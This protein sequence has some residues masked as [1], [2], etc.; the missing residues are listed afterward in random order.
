MQ[1]GFHRRSRSRRERVILRQYWRG[2]AALPVWTGGH[3]SDAES[4]WFMCLSMSSLLRITVQGKQQGYGGQGGELVHHWEGAGRSKDLQPCWR[5]WR[6]HSSV[7]W[8]MENNMKCMIP[9]GQGEKCVNDSEL[10]PEKVWKTSPDTACLYRVML[11]L[12]FYQKQI[13]I[14]KWAGLGRKTHWVSLYCDMVYE[15]SPPCFKAYITFKYC[16]FMNLATY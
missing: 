6:F 5:C 8:R 3:G 12:L 10:T 11:M 9:T 1:G 4:R 16:H 7:S 2:T 13:F 15:S 14:H